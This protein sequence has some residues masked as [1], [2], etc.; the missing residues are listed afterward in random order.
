MLSTSSTP[1]ISLLHA[2]RGRPEL[3][4]ATR[5]SWLEAAKSPEQV[6]HL[7]ALDADD[8]SSTE[9]LSN[10]YHCV[11]NQTNAGCVAAWNLAAAKSR[12]SILILLSDDWQARPGWD[13]EIIKRLGDLS[14]PKVLRVSDG[15]RRDDI[16]CLG[17]C[18]R[19]RYLQQGAILHEGYQGIYSDDEFSLRAYRDGVVV[20]ARD[21]QFVHAHPHFNPSIA[22]DETYLRQNSTDR[23][24]HGRQLFLRRNPQAL[25]HWLHPSDPQRKFVPWDPS[26]EFELPLISVIMRS[27][28]RPQ[29]MRRAV[30][31]VRQQSYPNIEL[32]VVAHGEA[33]QYAPVI[34]EEGNPSRHLPLQI[35]EAQP[36]AKLGAMLNAGASTAKGQW[37]I[38]LDD[39]DTWHSE[40]LE[41]LACGLLA[42]LQPSP[43]GSACQHTYIYENI[44]PD[45]EIVETHRVL[46]TPGFTRLLLSEHLGNNRL[47]IHS[48]LYEKSLWQ[49]LDGYDE[50]LDVAEDWDFS[51]RCLLRA[52]FLVVPQSLAYYHLR[53][54]AADQTQTSNA[55]N[56]A[57]ARS[58]LLNGAARVALNEPQLAAAALISSSIAELRDE[59]FQLR[60]QLASREQDI[61]KL[62][63]QLKDSVKNLQ[64]SEKSLAKIQAAVSNWNGRSWI[65]RAFHR[66]RV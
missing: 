20:D 58:H 63:T 46:A 28:N 14:Q 4:A 5:K 61:K 10:F 37:L 49:E 41:K 45:G 36:T 17:I 65:T 9:Q 55:I 7:F 54:Q 42:K 34:V 25:G 21:L 1:T 19:A 22:L 30:N 38:V 35:L 53:P 57:Y 16:L 64:K 13:Q 60:S 44:L 43:R 59:F 52:D 51:R 3:A 32:I 6:E 50:S 23:E 18:T 27:H 31:S 62:Q 11:V 66:L 39:D 24:I 12:G 40:C 33:L 47:A 15:H 26:A 48:F 2:T 56:H 29:M 8:V